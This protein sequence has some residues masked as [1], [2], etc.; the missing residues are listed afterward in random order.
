MSRAW[1]KADGVDLPDIDPGLELYDEDG[2]PTDEA[3]EALR[4]HQ[5]TIPELVALACALYRCGGVTVEH[6]PDGIGR[7]GIVFTTVTMGW[8][9]CESVDAVLHGTLFYQACWE[10]SSR[11]GVTVYAISQ[12]VWDSAGTGWGDPSVALA[13]AFDA[14]GP[15][16]DPARIPAVLDTLRRAWEAHPNATLAQL[17]VTTQ[18]RG[19]TPDDEMGRLFTELAAREDR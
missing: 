16:R 1:V 4:R 5:G 11:G 15:R 18:F 3:L 6:G 2:Y 17:L 19:N 7:P 9:G 14:D 12:G 8:S 10:S 13:A